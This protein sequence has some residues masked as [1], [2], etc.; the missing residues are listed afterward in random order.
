MWD[1]SQPGE[2]Q[3]LHF[4]L[5]LLRTEGIFPMINVKNTQLGINCAIERMFLAEQ[6]GFA[7]VSDF[8]WVS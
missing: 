6:L 2:N 4:K 1:Q 7:R 5:T 3:I 8:L